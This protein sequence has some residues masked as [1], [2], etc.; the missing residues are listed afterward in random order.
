MKTKAGTG[1]QCIPSPQ[2]ARC[3]NLKSITNNELCYN[4]LHAATVVGKAPSC[5]CWIGVGDSIVPYLCFHLRGLVYFIR[6]LV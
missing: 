5:T 6:G 4:G 1:R 3:E 2:V